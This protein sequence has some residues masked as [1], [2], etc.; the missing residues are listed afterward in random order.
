MRNQKLLAVAFSCLALASA[1]PTAPRPAHVAVAQANA[2]NLDDELKR[3]EKIFTRYGSRAVGGVIRR[4]ETKDFRGCEIMYE[5]TPQVAPDTKGFVP[6]IERT[7][8]D[9]SAL[10]P[11]QV[12]VREGK[13]GA[14]LS[15]ATRGGEPKIETRVASEPHQFGGATLLRSHYIF[16]TDKAAATE[17]REEFVRA[18]ELCQR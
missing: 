14:T 9:L 4:F 10:D 6:F 8:I 17:A 3:L 11:S 7:T 2:A 1:T 12:T 18:I 5:L 15:F 13:E 16:L